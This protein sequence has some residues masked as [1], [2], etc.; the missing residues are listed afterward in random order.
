MRLPGPVEIILIIIVAAIVLIGIRLIGTPAKR[1][2]QKLARIEATDEEDDEEGFPS[3][4]SSEEVLLEVRLDVGGRSA[5][6]V[7]LPADSCNG[8]EATSVASS[9]DPCNEPEATSVASGSGL[10]R[11]LEASSG[12]G[13]T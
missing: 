12:D 2:S 5:T 9:G 3:G 13:K 10:L 7:A 11:S 6:L 8:P 4:K 1:R